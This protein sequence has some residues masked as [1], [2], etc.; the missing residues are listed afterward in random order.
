MN[1]KEAEEIRKNVDDVW[2][3]WGPREFI[4]EGYLECWKNEVE[5]LLGEA[6]KLELPLNV[7]LRR[8]TEAYP[9]PELA[10]HINEFLSNWQK[11]KE[12]FK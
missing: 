4:A 10:K 7:L 8:F 1:R 11:A 9:E 5:P 12:R 3:N 6:E 2:L